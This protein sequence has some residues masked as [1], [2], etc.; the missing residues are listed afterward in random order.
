MESVRGYSRI[1]ER[2]KKIWIYIFQNWGKIILLCF[3]ILLFIGGL[4]LYVNK[5][6]NLGVAVS[7]I[8]LFVTL[9]FRRKI[10][11][12]K[13]FLFYILFLV[14]LEIS[15]FWSQ[16][17]ASTLE[18]LLLFTSGGFIWLLF[19]NL[20]N[21][22][23]NSF[24]NLIIIIGLIFG[25]SYL[26]NLILYPELPTRSW[27][28]YLTID[29]KYS[30]NHLGDLWAIVLVV[31][32]HRLIVERKWWHWLLITIGVYFLAI[33]LSRSAYL[34]LGVGIFYLFNNLGWAK[35]FKKL[36][37]LFIVLAVSLFLY[38]ANFKT[39]LFARPY[40]EQVVWGLNKWPLGVGVGNFDI[41]SKDPQSPWWA[42]P[43]SGVISSSAHNIFLEMIAGLGLIGVI[44]IGW[45]GYV[46]L[47]LLKKPKGNSLYIGLFLAISA[48][49]MFDTVYYIPSMLWLWF[50]SLAYSQREAIVRQTGFID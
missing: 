30:H 43:R 31:V 28:L 13:G 22:H 35:R 45:F 50:I 5:V 1:M 11:L 26:L 12:P 6:I 17:R 4:G 19:Y 47:D 36:Y 15:I 37:I 25:A 49:F 3:G 16:S 14:I 48:L 9:V 18:Y 24:G 21:F 20:G 8:S 7:A 34:A 46:L 39:T 40:F 38:A 27:T 29:K 42:V 2:M 44:F 10:I 23:K 33:S 32:G 41:I